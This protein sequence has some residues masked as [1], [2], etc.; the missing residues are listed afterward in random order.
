MTL[1]PVIFVAPQSVC[2]IKRD[3][4]GDIYICVLTGYVEPDPGGLTTCK[5]AGF[6]FGLKRY[7]TGHN[8]HDIDS[9]QFF[10]RSINAMQTCKQRALKKGQESISDIVNVWTA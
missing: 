7:L 8:G 4:I 9:P 10:K 1:S 6:D 5:I 3:T 2:T